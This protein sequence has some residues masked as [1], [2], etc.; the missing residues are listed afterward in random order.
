M[1]HLDHMIE[2]EPVQLARQ[3]VEERAE[4]LGVE[5]LEGRELPE[6]G[7]ELVAQLGKAGGEEALDEIAGLGEHLLLRDEAGALHRE[8]EALRR[9]GGPFAKA[10]RSLQPVMRGIDLDEVRQLAA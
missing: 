9:R 7:P 1:A 5:F 3:M 2:L 4:I 10:C 8:Y 6:H